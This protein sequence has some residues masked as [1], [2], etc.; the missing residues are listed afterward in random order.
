MAPSTGCATPVP[1]CTLA[2]R[3]GW[4]HSASPAVN[5]H[6][7][8]APGLRAIR[9][10]DVFQERE[11]VSIVTSWWQSNWPALV[12][13]GH[14]VRAASSA[15][16]ERICNLLQ[17]TSDRYQSWPILM[18][19]PGWEGLDYPEG[20]EAEC[21]T[22]SAVFRVACAYV[23]FPPLEEQRRG[24][25]L[26]SLY[27]ATRWFQTDQSRWPPDLCA[28]RPVHRRR[29]FATSLGVN[30]TQVGHWLSEQLGHVL[31][32]HD[33]VPSHVPILVVD[34]SATRRY[35]A[36]LFA[37]GV[38]RE[39][40]IWFAEEGWLANRTLHAEHVY[41]V[42]HSRFAY[43]SAGDYTARR[44][45]DAYAA[46]P[47][48]PRL[49]AWRRL[50]GMR[51]GTAVGAAPPPST[52][53]LMDRGL[54]RHEVRDDGVAGWFG[55]KHVVSLRNDLTARAFIN[56]AEVYVALQQTIAASKAAGR[57]TLKGW[58]PSPRGA[59]ADLAAI[60]RAGLIVAGHGAAVANIVFAPAGTPVVEI[61]FD[62]NGSAVLPGVA[63]PRLFDCPA[64]L[65]MLGINLGLPYWLVSASGTIASP[66]RVETAQLRL[67]VAQ[68]LEV[69][70]ANAKDA[71]PLPATVDAASAPASTA[72]SAAASGSHVSASASVC[73]HKG[74]KEGHGATHAIRRKYT[75]SSAHA[76]PKKE[77]LV[78]LLGSIRGGERAWRSLEQNV[79]RVNDADLALM[80]GVKA[81]GAGKDGKDGKGS[82]HSKKGHTPLHALAKY[83]WTVPERDNWGKE[84]DEIAD[85]MGVGSDFWQMRKTMIY[86]GDP[87][88]M[89]TSHMTSNPK[90]FV[91][92]LMKPRWL[93]PARWSAAINLCMRWHAKQ[94]IL[95]LQLHKW[96]RR[97]VITRSDQFY[98][99]PVV[100][101]DLGL[102]DPSRTAWRDWLQGK[103]R[104]VGVPEGETGE[105]KGICDRFM[106]C[107]RHDVIA[108]LS[109]ID[110]FVQQ[111]FRY[112]VG[113]AMFWTPERFVFIR[114]LEQHLL[115]RVFPRTMFTVAVPGDATRWSL[116]SNEVDV[117][118]G[119]HFKYRDEYATAKS[120]CG[121]CASSPKPSVEPYC[122][123]THRYESI[124]YL[125]TLLGGQVSELQVSGHCVHNFQWW[126]R[127]LATL[128]AL[129]GAAATCRAGRRRLRRL[130]ERNGGELTMQLV[131]APLL[132]PFA[133]GA[134][135]REREGTCSPA[136]GFVPE[137]RAAPLGLLGRTARA[138]QAV[139]GGALAALSWGP[140]MGAFPPIACSEALRAT[141]SATSAT[142]VT[143]VTHPAAWPAWRPTRLHRTSPASVEA[144]LAAASSASTALS[145]A[146]SAGD[147]PP[148][149]AAQVLFVGCARDLGAHALT[150]QSHIEQLGARYAEHRVLIWEDSS[151]GGRH[152][153]LLIHPYRPLLILPSPL[154]QTARGRRSGSGRR[155][156]AACE[157]SSATRPPRR[158]DTR[159]IGPRASPFVVTCC[160]PRRSRRCRPARSL[161][162]ALA[163]RTTTSPP[164]AASSPTAGASSPP[165]M[166]RSLRLPNT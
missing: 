145:P 63:F 81:D 48:T 47:A 24:K 65:G 11:G 12:R 62:N 42:V 151:T 49:P 123:L 57:L 18:G 99:C 152:P 95:K 142:S 17:P 100:L 64:T 51:W 136:T 139:V 166:P 133:A 98:A 124:A 111:P 78:I 46:T 28:A 72:V 94:H 87:N 89:N 108:C 153:C 15:H 77:T 156:T 107:S 88:L 144:S 134:E 83:V 23:E 82:G 160:S 53:L 3:Y 55:A 114:L 34:S 102:D 119:T 19:C 2:P 38:L 8:V 45:R 126:L 120:R 103:T 154:P 5:A 14:S 6:T 44:I 73:H 68:A 91:E 58:A 26:G 125:Q 71:P 13:Q 147:T 90:A 31:L 1:S 122:C 92:G 85:R 50:L 25:V 74:L 104:F 16:Q 149:I 79:L 141:A 121:K 86:E 33:S 54:S 132:A 161:R 36:P 76:L 118:Y 21:T 61:C 66:L 22:R 112:L 93:G 37:N 67:A 131:L 138:G 20:E 109:L 113:G 150:S 70:L 80:I 148:T 60:G 116:M 127:P 162:A 56:S 106:V 84:V 128:A 75:H 165:Q 117:T 59:A 27:D 40:R 29:A 39:D 96:Y 30:P 52:V 130:A 159:S 140:R 43:V 157:S 163:L 110:G 155:G 164:P 105:G 101:D 129:L 9:G 158:G 143:L 41:A 115:P 7:S 4:N 135:V 35:L 137:R 32:L 69:S 10:I 97:F 146:S